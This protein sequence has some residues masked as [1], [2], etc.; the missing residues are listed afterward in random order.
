MSQPLKTS[1]AELDIGFLLC[2]SPLICVNKQAH[3]GKIH[4]AE[5]VYCT[6]SLKN[7]RNYAWILDCS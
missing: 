1:P 2:L 4:F 6:D 3:V 7:I 5:P